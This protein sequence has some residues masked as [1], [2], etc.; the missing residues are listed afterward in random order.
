MFNA[1]WSQICEANYLEAV[2][3]ARHSNTETSDVYFQCNAGNP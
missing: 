1:T 3:F 2:T